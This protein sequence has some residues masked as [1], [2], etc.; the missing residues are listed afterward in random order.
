MV[1]KR[2]KRDERK[3]TDLLADGGELVVLELLKRLFNGEITDDTR[4]VDHAGAE[5]PEQKTSD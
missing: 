2:M 5:E 3:W 4:G 1:R